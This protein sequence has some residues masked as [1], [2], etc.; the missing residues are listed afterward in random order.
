MPT[1]YPIRCGKCGG[2]YEKGWLY[3]RHV[4]YVGSQTTGCCGW[5]P[6]KE[7]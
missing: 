6:P 1:K 2:L 3:C 5:R 4:R 7:E